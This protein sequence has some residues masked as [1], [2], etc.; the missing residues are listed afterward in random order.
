MTAGASSAGQRPVNTG[1]SPLD[2][3]ARRADQPVGVVDRDGRQAFSTSKRFRPSSS[4]RRGAH[5]GAVEVEG[6]H[7]AVSSAAV[8]RLIAVAPQ[9]ENVAVSA[10]HRQP[11]QCP[12]PAQGRPA[13]RPVSRRHPRRRPRH[14]H[15]S[16]HAQGAAPSAV[17]DRPAFDRAI[18]ARPSARLRANRGGRRRPSPAR[19]RGWHEHARARLAKR[20]HAVA[21]QDDR[22]SAPARCAPP[23]RLWR[24]SP[25]DVLVAARRHVA[26]GRRRH[27]PAVPGACARPGSDLVVLGFE[28]ADPHAYGRLILDDAGALLKIV[29][30]RR[31]RPRSAAGQAVQF[32][33]ATPPP[34]A[35]RPGLELSRRGR[36]TQNAKGEYLPDRGVGPGR[37]TWAL[38]GQ[39][40]LH[41]Q[42]T[43]CWGELHSR[44]GCRRTRTLP[45]SPPAAVLL[46]AGVSMPAPETR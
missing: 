7:D 46:D 37:A 43:A 18:D 8:E 33:G 16:L 1:E 44:T 10:G 25:G 6:H 28:A 27:G 39:G 40:G 34:A 35:L 2:R 30:A 21:I 22:R 14:A 11:R 42:K 9:G 24:A 17:G 32:R 38:Q 13:I 36:P 3:G 29:E 20:T 45:G 15:A 12:P 4:G 19:R 41:L 5:Q 31:R 23:S 26:A